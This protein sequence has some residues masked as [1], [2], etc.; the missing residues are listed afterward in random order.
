MREKV[1]EKYGKMMYTTSAYVYIKLISGRIR[2]YNNGI[3][4]GMAGDCL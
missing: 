4:T 3:I 2:W 1:F